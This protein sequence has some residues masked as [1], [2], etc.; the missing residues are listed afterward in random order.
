MVEVRPCKN[1]FYLAASIYHSCLYVMT[2]RFCQKK[3]FTGIA[4]D[5]HFF[6]I[7]TIV[8]R[9]RSLAVAR[10][11]N[12]GVALFLFFWRGRPLVS[13]HSLLSAYFLAVC[14]YKRMGLITRYLR[15]NRFRP[16]HNRTSVVGCTEHEVSAGRT[17]IRCFGC[18]ELYNVDTGG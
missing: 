14:R 2:H 3:I 4:T 13:A 7:R 18:L 16:R 5:S 1:L 17:E 8:P 6:G 15:A 11:A 10:G 9:T 12:V